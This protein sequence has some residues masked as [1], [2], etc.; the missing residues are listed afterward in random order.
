MNR[1]CL[2]LQ[3]TA[4]KQQRFEVTLLYEQNSFVSSVD[5]REI[6]SKEFQVI[7]LYEQSLFA[8]FSRQ[9]KNREQ[10]AK[11]LLFFN[12]ANFATHVRSN[13][14]SNNFTSLSE[15]RLQLNSKLVT[16]LMFMFHS[17]VFAESHH[18]LVINTSQLN[19]NV[20]RL[21]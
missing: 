8:I 21:L 4:K 17:T 2:Y 6:K 19:F 12:C 18:G 14:Q 20:P 11:N 10:R 5:S 1:T 16:D 7:L 3:Q 15:G 13:I 9:Q